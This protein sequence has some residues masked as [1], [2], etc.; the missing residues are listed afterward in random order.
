MDLRHYDTKAHGLD[1]VYEDVQPGFSTATGVGRTSELTLFATRACRPGADR[2][3]RAD[4]KRAAAPRVLARD[5]HTAGVF[6]IWSPADRSTPL[7]R[8]LRTSSTRR[9]R[10]TRRRSSSAT[11]TGSGISA[12][13]CIPTTRSATCGATTSG[14]M[15]WDNTELAHRHVALV[16]LPAHRPGRYLPPGGGR[17][18]EHERGGRVPPR[19]VRRAGL[20]PQRAPLGLRRE[21]GPHQPGGLEAVLLL[22][23]YRRAGRRP[24]ARRWS[25]PTHKVVE[26]DPMRV[27]QPK[28]AR[29]P[30]SRPHSRRSGLARLAS[31]TG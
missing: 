13:S 5:I 16:Q 26:I 22:P 11:G 8:R 18:P 19:A 23:D 28:N 4:R 7:K 17:D 2:A 10:S 6:G 20:A 29:R 25:M 15:A 14:G 3:V 21:G 12:T 1:A 27:A 24:D 9:S 31:A 30:V